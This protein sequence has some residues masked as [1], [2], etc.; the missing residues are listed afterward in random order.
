MT[1]PLRS[2]RGRRRYDGEPPARVLGRGLLVA[3]LIGGL[4]WLATAFYDG[5]PGRDYRLVEARVPRIGSLLAHDPVRIGGVRVGQV[6][7]IGLAPDGWSALELQIE[8][9]THIP[10]GTG[11]RVRANGLLGARFVE[12]VPGR[13]RDELPAGQVLRGDDTSLTSGD[14]DA[15]DTFDRETRGALRAVLG[16]LGAG[17]AG[18]GR[19]VNDLLRAG[20]REIVPTKE[21]F[22]ELRGAGGALDRLLPALGRAVTPLDAEREALGRLPDAAVRA[23]R[24]LTSERDATRETLAELP[25]ALAAGGSGLSTARPLLQAARELSGAVR[26]TLPPAPGGLRAASALLEEARG[27]LA[28]TDDLLRDA[29]PAVPAALALTRAADPLLR[30]AGDLLD[31]LAPVL[32]KLGPYGCDLENFGAVFRSMTGLGTT[33]GEGPNG[34][35]MQFRL[36]AASPLPTEAFSTR[37]VT[38]M[39]RREGY[40]EPCRYL[41]KP[42]PIIERPVAL[43]K[44]R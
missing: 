23:L 15:L 29:R 36:Q 25:P 14:T 18:R 16:E 6:T 33:N 30:P 43:G 19:D 37:D 42:Y 28:Q 41:A 20:A 32:R 26:R 21:L 40:P 35:L 13:S 5:V 38:G 31:D 9:G 2:S 1:G 7:G 8:P 17:L 22:G 11:I 44:G 3:A 10:A 27:P 4:A 24:P 34:P 12:L 39:L